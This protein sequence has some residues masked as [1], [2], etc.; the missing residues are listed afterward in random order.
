MPTEPANPQVTVEA[1]TSRKRQALLDDNG[2]PVAVLKKRATAAAPP[3]PAPPKKQTPNKNTGTTIDGSN[4]DP[5][6]DS[7]MDVDSD[8]DVEIL[9]KPEEDPEAELGMPVQV[10]KFLVTV[11]SHSSSAHVPEMDL[12]GL[13]VL[14]AHPPD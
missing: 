3:K 13:C 2:E 8:D 6:H 14:Q 11:L 10:A 9:E 5:S 1:R 7:D 12:T 4:D